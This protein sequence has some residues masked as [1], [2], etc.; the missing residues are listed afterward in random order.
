MSVELII[1]S[2]SAKIAEGVVELATQMAADVTMHAVGGDDDGGIGTSFDRVQ[3]AVESAGE[4][5]VLC[6]LGSAVM[7][8]ESVI[9]FL[10]E[11]AAAR[12]R[13]V[14]APIVEGAVAA[15]VAAQSGAPL[16]EV[17]AAAESAGGSIAAD[18]ETAAV[19]EAAS[20]AAEDGAVT[21]TLTL[22]NPSGLH[23][24]PASELTKIAAGFDA[25]VT[26]NG[27]NA[28]SLLS[29]MALGLGQGAE[30][31]YRASGPDAQ[32]AID[33]LVAIT[34]DGFGE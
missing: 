21:A 6:D 12:V 7:T 28:K 2:H 1:V 14:D 18:S 5:V 23:A 24:R 30:V 10:D 25:E 8:A 26:V 22:V 4:A 16:A 20:A 19:S 11:D 9:E 3:A 31:V 32:S 17:A 13:L 27:V 33:A 29:I 34:S 15:A